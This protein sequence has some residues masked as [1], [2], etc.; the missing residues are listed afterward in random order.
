MGYSPWGLKELDTSEQLHFLSFS[1]SLSFFLFLSFSLSSS[2][3]F[4]LPFFLSFLCMR[5]DEWCKMNI[6]V[7]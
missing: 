5:Q 4:S 6:K 7:T 1:L 3:S 2:L